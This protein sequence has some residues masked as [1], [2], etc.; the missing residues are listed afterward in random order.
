MKSFFVFPTITGN[1][2]IGELSRAIV[3]PSGV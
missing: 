3:Q 1:G 2:W